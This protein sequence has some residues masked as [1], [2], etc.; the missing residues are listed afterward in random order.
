MMTTTNEPMLVMSERHLAD[1]LWDNCKDLDSEIVRHSL[2]AV[3]AEMKE[4]N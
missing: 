4:A 1:F 3:G 2:N